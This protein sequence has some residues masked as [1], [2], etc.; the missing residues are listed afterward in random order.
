LT[1]RHLDE[2]V[3]ETAGRLRAHGLGPHSRIALVVDNGPEAAT[4]FRFLANA[5][6]VAP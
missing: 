6:A 4:A 1:Y 2:F 3:A 5:D